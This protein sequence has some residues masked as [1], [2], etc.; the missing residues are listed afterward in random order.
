MRLSSIGTRIRT[1]L[2]VISLLIP[3]GGCVLQTQSTGPTVL[4]IAYRPLVAD[5][6]PLIAAFERENPGITVE[7]F[8]ATPTNFPSLSAELQAGTLDVLR[9]YRST[10]ATLVRTGAFEPLDGMLEAG[11]WGKVRE[12]YFSGSWEGLQVDG[13]QYAVPAGLDPYVAYVNL[14][15][16][17]AAGVQPPT[18]DWTVDDL[19]MLAS[20]VNQPVGTPGE[21]QGVVYGFG[22]SYLSADPIIFTYLHGG[23]IVDDF[24]HPTTVLIDDPKTIEATSWYANLILKY[25]VSPKTG[26]V[27]AYF[28][29]GGITAAESQGFCAMW[30]GTFSSRGGPDTAKW[31]FKWQMLPLP[32]DAQSI[33]VG[34]VDGYYIPA[35]SKHQQ[36]A[37]KLIRYLSDQ[38][39]QSGVRFPVR[40]SLAANPR[41]QQLMGAEIARIGTL[42]ANN[43]VVMP[44]FYGRGGGGQIFQDYFSALFQILETGADPQMQ[45]AAAQKTADARLL[46]TP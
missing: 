39:Q 38:W 14:D 20:Q 26:I 30:F 29:T 7:I 42:A 19:L 24:D 44:Q 6:K 11:D 21:T 43:L 5:L 36:E 33:S 10:M 46:Q 15:A 22:T 27:S 4:R 45:M 32:R 1:L 2:L 9:D 13:K 41:Y 12:D 3:L 23:G 16:F 28:R 18:T 25:K 40:K 35:N 17:T 37:L 8:E 31:P 34:D